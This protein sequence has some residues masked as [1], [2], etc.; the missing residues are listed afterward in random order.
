MRLNESLMTG[1]KSD[2]IQKIAKFPHLLGHYLGF[3]KLGELHSDWIRDAFTAEG[4]DFCLQ[5]H[6][7]SY[8]TTSVIVVGVIWWLFFHWEDRILI[9]RKD[10]SKASEVLQV[11]GKILKS[12]KCRRLFEYIYGFEYILTTDTNGRISWNLKLTNTNEA[13]VNAFGIGQDLTGKHFDKALCD[14]FVTIKDRISKAERE[15]TIIFIQD[16]RANILDPGKHGIYTGTPWHNADAWKLFKNIRKYDVYSTGIGSF[17][18]EYI[19]HLKDILPPSLFSANYELRHISDEESLFSDPI[20][21]PW[22][23]AYNAVGHID[24]KYQGKDTGAFTILAKRSDGKVQG[25]GYL[26]DKHINIEYNNLFRLWQK[27]RCGTVYLETNA[28]K[29]YASRDLSGLGMLT[30]NYHEKEN[31]H[32]KIIQNLVVNWSNIIWDE[33]TD[34]EFLAQIMEYREGQEPDDCADSVASCIRQTGIF[35]KGGVSLSAE[36]YDDQYS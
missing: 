6:R 2:F 1:S 18:A 28:D 27:Y 11:I 19:S 26:F 8:K 33:E 9:L 4:E 10:F 30:S 32:V 31:K 3:T 35:G 22:D 29:G 25:F 5:A 12:E 16:L 14:D 13:N 24:A 7:G 20:M 21:G 34:P 23:F 36:E 17:T 15:R